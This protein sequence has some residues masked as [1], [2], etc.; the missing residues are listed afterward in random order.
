M[1]R[2]KG[3]FSQEMLTIRQLYSTRVLVIAFGGQRNA[4]LSS[5]Q[6]IFE[7]AK[8]KLTARPYSKEWTPGTAGADLVYRTDYYSR[9][10]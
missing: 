1:S 2:P 4:F 6:A 8:M 5:S 10:R 3:M 7:L 9:V